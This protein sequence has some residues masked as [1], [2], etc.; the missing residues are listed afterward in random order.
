VIDAYTGK[1]TLYDITTPKKPDPILQAWESVFPNLF[2]PMKY[3]TAQLQQHLKYPEDIFS[4]QSA[5]F[6]RYHITSPSQF[7]GNSDGWSLSPTFG[8]GPPSDTIK[9]KTQVDKQGYVVSQSAERMDPL[10]QIYAPPGSSDPQYTM[11]DAYVAASASSGSTS[12][13]AGVG[14]LAA[15]DVATSDPNDYGAI[16]V[17][18]P[19]TRVPINGPLLAEEKMIGYGPASSAI[20][21]LNQQRSSVF[22]GNVLMVPVGGSILYVLPMYV[23]SNAASYPQLENFITQYNNSIG[24]SRTLKGALSKVL[25]GGGATTGPGTSGLTVA[26]L[27]DRAQT[28][29]NNAQTALRAGNF[30][31]YQHDLAQENADI[32]KALS[33]L[34]GA[35]TGKHAR[36]SATTRT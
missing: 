34:S 7:Y 1:V 30:V 36:T 29:Y 14:N 20:S 32:T 3:M 21:L 5:I 15:F 27:L 28:N 10:Y 2:T 19:K 18:R 33:Q 6:G 9:L 12:G 25:A 31:A 16:T 24:F 11:T 35:T 13:N 23:T 17:Y 4:I 26:Q 22:L 8:A